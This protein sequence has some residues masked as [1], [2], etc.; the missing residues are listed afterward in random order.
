MMKR[1]KKRAGLTGRVN[2]HTFR[3]AFAREYILKGGDLASG[4]E[5]MGHTQITG[6]KQFYAVFQAEELREKHDRFSPV[7]RLYGDD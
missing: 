2:P 6:T 7:G 4:S 5:M 3:D 1:Y